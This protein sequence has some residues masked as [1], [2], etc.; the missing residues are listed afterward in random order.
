MLKTSPRSEWQIANIV[1]T[2]ASGL[3][4]VLAALGLVS[5]G[6]RREEKCRERGEM[7]LDVAHSGRIWPIRG[8]FVVT[9][10]GGKTGLLAY[11]A[12][13]RAC[14][15]RRDSEVDEHCSLRGTC[16]GHLLVPVDRS[17]GHTSAFARP[18]AE[19][20]AIDR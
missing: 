2:V 18:H 3:C 7:T 11:I 19:R 8:D 13:G 4:V 16:I 20:S 15:S 1:R 14:S 10:S 12:P 6:A 5:L 9:L 17:R